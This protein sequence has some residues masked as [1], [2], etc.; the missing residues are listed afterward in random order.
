MQEEEKLQHKENKIE[1]DASVVDKNILLMSALR[2]MKKR[3]KTGMT[4]KARR[5]H[6]RRGMR[7]VLNEIL[8][9]QG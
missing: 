7:I 2:M 9:P 6:S 8:M 4:R 3:N 5:C 1:E